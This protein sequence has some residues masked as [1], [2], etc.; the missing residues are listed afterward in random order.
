MMLEKRG[1]ESRAEKTNRTEA[2]VCVRSVGSSRMFST[3]VLQS[4]HSPGGLS[5][6][7]AVIYHQSKGKHGHL[8]S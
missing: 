4:E 1:G 5:A 6:A 2:A 3:A 8:F 7:G